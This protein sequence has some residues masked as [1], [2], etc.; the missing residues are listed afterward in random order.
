MVIG[1]GD[2][3]VAGLR[4][5]AIDRERNRQ[6]ASSLQNLRQRSAAL[7]GC[8]QNYDDDG[9][10]ISREASHDCSER[11]QSASRPTHNNKVLYCH[12]RSSFL[13]SP[14]RLAIGP[15][16]A[17]SFS[18]PGKAGIHA[19]AGPRFATKSLLK[20]API[21]AQNRRIGG[22]LLTAR[23]GMAVAKWAADTAISDE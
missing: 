8:M 7:R 20:Y 19:K 10:Q 4:S 11:F 9:T 12:H 22:P 5:G 23:I 16:K 15:Q 21:C 2:I 14:S 18:I 3:N 17:G 1:R 13:N 6:V